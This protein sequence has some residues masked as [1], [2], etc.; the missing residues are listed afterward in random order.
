MET[1]KNIQKNP[2][3][4]PKIAPQIPENQAQISPKK[5]ANYK[6]IQHEKQKDFIQ[7]KVKEFS[8]NIEAKIWETQ[9]TVAKP[10]FM[11]SNFTK[12][13]ASILQSM[14]EFMEGYSF[15]DQ[16]YFMQNFY[17][18]VEKKLLADYVLKLKQPYF[19]QIYFNNYA[20]PKSLDIKFL[21]THN[22][23]E[24]QQLTQKLAYQI[25]E[26]CLQIEL[27]VD[28]TQKAEDYGLYSNK[29]SDS[30][31][32]TELK[33]DLTGEKKRTYAELTVKYFKQ[34]ISYGMKNISEILWSTGMSKTNITYTSLL[35]V[36]Y[37]FLGT[38][39]IP[40]SVII[41][42][43]KLAM[44]AG[45]VLGS[46]ALG[47]I[48]ENLDTN[49]LISELEDLH[50]VFYSITEKLKVW[51][52]KGEKA[53]MNCLASQTPL[54]KE[55]QKKELDQTF[56]ELLEQT[57]KFKEQQEQ[58]LQVI[59][60]VEKEVEGGWTVLE[61]KR[62]AEPEILDQQQIIEMKKDQN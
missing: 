52:Q 3:Q 16:Q 40:I 29:M 44:I 33:K 26:W 4:A 43:S 59:D 14:K 10:P 32:Y 62:D 13:R 6:E 54:Q 11:N 25:T 12:W 15:Q 5:V 50:A 61:H 17:E 36:Y 34:F 28:L 57:E 20:V 51:N 58:M 45:G 37:T 2:L 56:K 22:T 48:A 55:I 35:L 21:K 24:L 49:E 53:I 41:P 1:K 18:Q 9:L 31:L 30:Q 46:L 42:K 27:S 23:Q 60:L 47:K 39:S 7:K 38:G 19:D 8:K